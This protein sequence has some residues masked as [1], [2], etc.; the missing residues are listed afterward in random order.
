M[1]VY[2]FLFQFVRYT[3]PFFGSSAPVITSPP[4]EVKRNME[5]LLPRSF[6]AFDFASSPQ[7]LQ[8]T[9]SRLGNKFSMYHVPLNGFIISHYFGLAAKNVSFYFVVQGN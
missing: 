6:C 5:V 3:Y 2:I 4:V 1:L 9:L 7:L 8:E